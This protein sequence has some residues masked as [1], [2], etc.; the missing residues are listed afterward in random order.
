M[1]ET[2]KIAFLATSISAIFA[3]PFTFFSARASSCWGRG[4]NILLQ[5]I[6]AAVRS[7]HP[8]IIVAPIAIVLAWIGPTAG[9]LA[10]TL[11]SNCSVYCKLFRIAQQHTSLSWSVLL[12]VYFPGLAFRHFP[13]NILIATVLGFLGGGGI[14]FSLQ[15]DLSLLNYSDAG[16]A[17]LAIIIA[18]GS[19]DLLSRIVWYN[20]EN[21]STPSPPEKEEKP[22][23]SNTPLTPR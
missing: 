23:K 14:G 8:L 17:I 19:L 7:V 1:W 3:I 4:F 16:V 20:S 21:W 12:Q 6:L 22:L 5:P 9:V 11:F 10:L 13:I 15:Q 2:I 18:S